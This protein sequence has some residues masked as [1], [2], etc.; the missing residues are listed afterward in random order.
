MSQ[1]ALT[2]TIGIMEEKLRHFFFLLV[3]FLVGEL[4]TNV[5]F[6]ASHQPPELVGPEHNALFTTTEV[7]TPQI[8]FTWEMSAPTGEF[9]IQIA[10]DAEF[11]KIIF[12]NVISGKSFRLRQRLPEGRLYWRVRYQKGKLNSD[13]SESRVF[14]ILVQ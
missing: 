1:S 6:A 11:E 2:E 9:E 10:K 13:W 3:Y 4:L 8:E 12:K 5:S 7:T 14:E